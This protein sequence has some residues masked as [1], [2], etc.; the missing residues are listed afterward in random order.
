MYRELSPVFQKARDA[1]ESVLDK[2][3]FQLMSEVI[4]HGHM[5]SGYME[6]HH[7]A[8][9]IRLYW[10]GKEGWLSLAGAI[11]SDQHTFPDPASWKDLDP[12]SP[13]PQFSFLRPGPAADARIAELLDQIEIFRVQ[14]AA[15]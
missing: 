4:H 5:G 15:V 14:R 1:V 3:G 6:Y 7:R 10:D 9:W 8:H 11:S 12:E 13:A 2:Y